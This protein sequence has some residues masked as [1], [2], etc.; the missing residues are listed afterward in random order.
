M[1]LYKYLITTTTFDC[2]QWQQPLRVLAEPTFQLLLQCSGQKKWLLAVRGF[3]NM[4]N[5]LVQLSNPNLSEDAQANASVQDI[6][7]GHSPNCRQPQTKRPFE[8]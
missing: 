7:L 2:L 1:A 3:M 5:P 4:A 6:K 8:I